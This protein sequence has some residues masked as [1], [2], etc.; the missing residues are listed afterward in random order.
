MIIL[1]VADGPDASAALVVNGAL[2]AAVA[3]ERIDRER[4]SRAFPSGA[5]DAVLDVAGLR[6][7]DVDRV[8]FGGT[9]SHASILR[10][11]PHLRDRVTP[12]W[13]EAYRGYQAAL[14]ASGLYMVEQDI[15]RKLLEPKMRLL[16]FEKA[17][18]DLHEHDRAHATAAYRCQDRSDAL[19]ITLD[20]PGDGAAVTV[21]VGRH[22]Q[23]DR[24]FLQTSL[25]SISTFPERIAQVLQ[26]DAI[27]LASLAAGGTVPDVL[28]DAFTRQVG[29][30]GD[31]FSAKGLGGN[32]DPL[33]AL[34]R[35]HAPADVAAAAQHA[36]EEAVAA[37]VRHHVARMRIGHVVVAG[38]LFA[39]PRLAA[40]LLAE[41]TVESLSVFP[42]MG[43][44]GLAI[45]AALG[46]AGTPM[47]RLATSG[48]GPRYTETH[49]YKA[50]SVASLPRDKVDDPEHAA[51]RLI[52]AGRTVARFDGGLEVGPRA[53]GNRTV[54]FR[55]DD[56]AIRSRALAAL[57]RRDWASVGCALLVAD[58]G[59]AFA[60]LDRSEASA[61]FRT[62]APRALPAFAA[63]HP[64]AIQRDGT[65][66]P[67]VVDPE[68]APGMATL[69]REV[70]RLT[71]RHAVAQL[72]F[73]LG[74]EPIVCSPGDAIRSWRASDI[75]ALLLGPYL[76]ER[77]SLDT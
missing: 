65:A 5:I 51:A 61:R 57:K 22:L 74:D 73:A 52:A 49:C 2:V 32:T 40:R 1:G 30:Q 48:L 28:R 8:V 17:S 38:A 71:G 6:A 62:L 11:R 15:A 25:A 14:R 47:R 44:E 75:D 45:G 63:A 72:D 3:Q 33:L 42:A 43:D 58:A 66:L 4:H 10:A 21:S 54:L 39:N 50:L 7:R 70:R 68:D 76:V 35:R 18:I 16:G 77:S 46:V 34:V 64:G 23:L 27:H 53:L 9:S 31:G 67:Y 41:P 69:L 20:T 19:V 12:R 29:T 59:G 56:A 60:D 36:I 26:I 55:A 24:V 13:R 37:F